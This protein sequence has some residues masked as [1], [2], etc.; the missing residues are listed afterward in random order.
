MAASTDRIEAL[1]REFVAEGRAQQAAT[2]AQLAQLQLDVQ[3]QTT[4]IRSIETKMQALLKQSAETRA[5]ANANQRVLGG[6]RDAFVV[7]RQ[8]RPFVTNAPHGSVV[9][10]VFCAWAEATGG[11]PSE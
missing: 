7:R 8:N 9:D 11:D 10:D 6:V 1:V 4:Q 2:A 5:V 3:A